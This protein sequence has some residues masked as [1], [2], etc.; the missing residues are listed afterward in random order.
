MQKKAKDKMIALKENIHSKRTP[1]VP[2][3]HLALVSIQH[4]EAD[5]GRDESAFSAYH[6]DGTFASS[7]PCSN[8]LRCS[9]IKCHFL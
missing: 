8:L 5:D 6:K 9:E 1:C 4:I 7:S 3:I 2:Q